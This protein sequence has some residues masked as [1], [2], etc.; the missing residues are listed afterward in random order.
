VGGS[1]MAHGNVFS[2]ITLD[3]NDG[4]ID[5]HGAGFMSNNLFEQINNIQV[6]GGAATQ[7][8]PHAGHYN[9]FW[10]L[11][12]NVTQGNKKPGLDFFSGYWNYPSIRSANGGGFRHDC[13][14]LHPK[15]I[16]VGVYH[17]N[18]LIEVEH[19]VNDRNDQWIYNEGFNDPDVTPASL[20][21]AQLESRLKGQLPTS[22][23]S[24]LSTNL[25]WIEEESVLFFQDK[26]GLFFSKSTRQVNIEVYDLAGVCLQRLNGQF[27]KGQHLKFN[28][29][30]GIYLVKVMDG[31]NTFVQKVRL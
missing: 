17:P 4:M 24:D 22:L 10:N 13:Y 19:S 18:N 30:S 28:R 31:K 26:N 9:V 12:G 15:S 8:V 29:F 16:L 2:N 21:N 25:N 14:K 7:N 3:D 23:K 20:Y 5:F 6:N 27:E 11:I 1:A